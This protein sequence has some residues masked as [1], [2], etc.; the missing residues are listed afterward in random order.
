MFS[1]SFKYLFPGSTTPDEGV[2]F[3][4]RVAHAL[5]GPEPG[6]PNERWERNALITDLIAEFDD[7]KGQLHR[8][9]SKGEQF[10]KGEVHGD[11]R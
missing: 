5:I 3:L 7:A 1:S 8:L 6:G 2:L 11:E 9:K 4:T 10:S